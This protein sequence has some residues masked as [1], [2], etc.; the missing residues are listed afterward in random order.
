VG[1]V[2]VGGVA[3][4]GRAVV[5][6]ETRNVLAVQAVVDTPRGCAIGERRELA[7]V[8]L[9]IAARR[10]AFRARGTILDA[11]AFDA[12]PRETGSAVAFDAVR[13]RCVDTLVRS[14]AL[15]SVA[16]EGCTVVIGD[17]RHVLAV[18]AVV[19]SPRGCPIG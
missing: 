14:V 11:G 7:L 8:G 13:E 17:A 18:Q 5:V 3:G 15:G 4:Q 12:R 16:R 10:L 9:C 2:A 1:S 19:D 6:V